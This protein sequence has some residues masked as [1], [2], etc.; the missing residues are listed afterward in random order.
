VVMVCGSCA[1]DTAVH[2]RSI[3][4]EPLSTCLLVPGARPFT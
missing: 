2:V 1:A 4:T 3:A